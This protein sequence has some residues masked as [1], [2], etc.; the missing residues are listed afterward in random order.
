MLTDKERTLLKECHAEAST[1][2]N[3][4]EFTRGDSSSDIDDITRA[5]GCAGNILR[6]LEKVLAGSKEET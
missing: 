3:S 5:D 1:C 4:L 6:L 2:R